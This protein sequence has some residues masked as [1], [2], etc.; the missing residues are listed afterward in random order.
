M[1]FGTFDAVVL[2]ASI[3]A[4]FPED[5]PDK[6]V[7]AMRHLQWSIV[8][9]EAMSSRNALAKSAVD[10]LRTFLERLKRTFPRAACHPVAG[11]ALLSPTGSSTQAS[12]LAIDVTS[13]ASYT[14]NTSRSSSIGLSPSM[15][16]T[17]PAFDA[18]GPPAV[19]FDWSLIEPIY[20]MGDIAY[21][22]LIGD[23]DDTVAAS[24]E[25]D[26]W[27]SAEPELLHF[28]GDFGANSVW[29]VLNQDFVNRRE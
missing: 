18:W 11:P 13:S 23:L 1:F 19:P 22:D 8:R 10:T 3:Y 26:I 2:M 6:I 28:S 27:P 21:N 4:F 16:A 24:S 25:Q 17:A 20:A 5:H 7:Q 15:L 12:S 14:D 29:S 9:F